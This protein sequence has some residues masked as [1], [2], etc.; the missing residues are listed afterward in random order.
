MAYET[1]LF[2]KNEGVA[3]ITLN[4]PEMRNALNKVM[5]REL[6]D[7]FRQ[8]A[9]DSEVRAIVLTGSGKGFCSGQDLIELQTMQGDGLTVGDALRS[10]LNRLI[11]QMHELEKPII[12]AINGVAAGAGS[13]L[14]LATDLRIASDEASFV[15]AA[16]VNIGIIPDGGGTYLLPHLV[17]TSK[18]LE[19]AL[20]TSASDRL[21]AQEAAGLNLV[22]R[23]VSHDDLMTLTHEWAHRLSTMPTFAIGLT[24]RAMYGAVHRTL[25]QALDYEA[26]VQEATFRSHDFGEGVTAFIEKRAPSFRGN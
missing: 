7:A 20:F 2:D 17:G 4:R 21:S 15:F 9:R 18:A 5:Y 26:Q 25:A 6:M 11:L 3:T 12:G 16:F 19:L 13:S 24:K 8:V 10:G 1:I 22:N 23:V 14:A